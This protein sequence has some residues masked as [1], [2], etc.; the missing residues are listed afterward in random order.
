[1]MVV[2]SAICSTVDP[3]ALVINI[4]SGVMVAETAYMAAKSAINADRAANYA[5]A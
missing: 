1:M 2:P 4:P 3:S 5:A